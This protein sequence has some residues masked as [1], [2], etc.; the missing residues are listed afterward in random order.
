MSR[1]VV[2]V[3][4]L[5]V[6]AAVG[7]A[8]IA[9]APSSSSL[10]RLGVGI[11]K[12]RLGMSYA[13][14]RRALGRPQLVNR[15]QDRGFGNRYVE[16]LW[17]YGDWRVGLLGPRGRERVVRVATAVRRER[18]PER[19]G[20]GSTPRQL[21]RAYRR[22]ADCISREYDT[23]DQ[24]TWIVVRGPAGRMTA[25]ALWGP[26]RGYTRPRGS[27]FVAEVMVQHAWITPISGRCNWDWTRG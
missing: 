24:G 19:I 7:A 20:V 21:A 23:P 17:N 14:V 8:P 12:V 5:L 26:G 18:T 15:V 16:Y 9:S 10:I 13:E 11:G 25:F 2:A 1:L 27:T 6:A 22:R 4:S 3:S